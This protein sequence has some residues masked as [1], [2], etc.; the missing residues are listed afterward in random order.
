MMRGRVS[1]GNQQA[2]I[3]DQIAIIDAGGNAATTTMSLP[4][5]F[6][7]FEIIMIEERTSHAGV[8]TPEERGLS[9]TKIAIASR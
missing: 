9:R 4:R 2:Q 5:D 6:L 1:S 7:L 8:L 3:N